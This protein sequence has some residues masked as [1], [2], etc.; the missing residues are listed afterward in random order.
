MV[1]YSLKNR[2]Y[3]SRAILVGRREKI[4]ETGL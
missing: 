1:G 2:F 3:T 4:A